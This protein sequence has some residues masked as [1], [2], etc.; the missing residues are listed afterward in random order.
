MTEQ[1]PASVYDQSFQRNIGILSAEEQQRLRS[2]TVAV[3]GL[4]GIGGNV[5]VQLA[6][7]GVGRF[8][9]ADFDRFELANINRQYGAT[10]D[11][12]GRLKIEVMAE[13]LRRINPEVE[14]QTFADGFTA[15][16]GDALLAGA[17]LA[18]DAVDFY[19]I[20][21]HVQLHRE[22]RRHGLYTLMGSPIGFSAVLQVFDPAGMSLEEYCGITDG[23]D[24]L[25]Q[26]LRY[27]CGLVPELAHIDYYD[28]STARSN[29]DFSAGVGPSMA[30]ACGLAASL[31]S[32]EAVLLLLGRRPAV[33]IPHTAQFDPYTLRYERT[34]LPGGMRDYDPAPAITRIPDKSSLVPQVLDFLYGKS[35]TQ[36][37]PVDG[38]E[39]F[40][41]EEGA[42]EPVVLVSPLGADSSFWSRQVPAL[43][44]R[45]VITYDPR[46]SGVST[47]CPDGCSV[48]L[49]ADDLVRLLDHLQV[50]P[51]HLVGV[52]LGGLVAAEAAAR[53]PD[54]ARSLTL[55]AAY[56]A[57][58]D[59]LR[60]IT[61]RWRQT[62]LT[63]SMEDLFEE[64][65]HWLFTEEYVRVNRADMDKLR[66]FFRL[67]VQDPPS[68]RQQSLAGVRHDARPAL[69]AVS[70]PALVL[71]G[72]ADRLIPVAAAEEVAR[73][74]PDARLV[75]LP[76]ASHFMAW[77][78]A[79]DFNAELAGFLDRL[80]L[81]D[82]DRPGERE[83]AR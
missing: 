24:P 47:P 6:R 50:G 38:A 36:R 10:T 49:L 21:T 78:N 74:L 1:D 83:A 58:D 54:L 79:E 23:M 69:R 67:T 18:L 39:L 14:V 62:S 26:Q 46:G 61:E 70:C 32:I 17:D 33:T 45:R 71:H 77:E 27:A 72:G 53:R 37:A 75:V 52:A 66:T 41:R 30:G 68:F 76:A 11:T 34:Y 16:T 59:R 80:A 65:L 63:R 13:E 12:V 22:T 7:M 48:E 60:E 9:L 25:E 19:S 73:L 44:G 29:T 4:G 35:A 43:A 28:V 15:E 20:S 5:V 82:A 3:A 40:W 2:A 64:V 8:R 56:P 31:V 81:A 55:A 57:A 51:A 42:G